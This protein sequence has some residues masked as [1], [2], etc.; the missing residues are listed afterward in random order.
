MIKLK[1]TDVIRLTS[2]LI[3]AL[4]LFVIVFVVDF[5][6]IFDR[7]RGLDYTPSS[8]ITNLSQDLRLSSRAKTILNATHPT[9][10]PSESFNKYCGV[11]NSD[12]VTLG[13]YS[14][15]LIYLYD[16]NDV[17]L[18]GIKQST[19]AHELLHAVWDRTPENERENLEKALSQIYDNN[20]KKLESR[21]KLYSEK[22]HYDEL[23]SI[24]GTEIVMYAAAV[25][26][27]SSC[28]DA[29]KTLSDHYAKYF[30][31]QSAVVAF[32]KQYES[33]FKELEAEANALYEQIQ[34]N[35]AQIASL[36]KAC[37]DGITSLN[38]AIAVFNQ[39]ANNGYFQNLNVFEAE[40][41]RLVARQTEL[42]NNYK[43]L[44]RLVASTN[45][46]IDDFNGNIAKTQKLIDNINSST[47]QNIQKIED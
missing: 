26:P 6:V 12:T 16:T 39:R 29:V 5:S 25:C 36:T 35:Q 42:Q 27:E 17:G 1:K 30:N 15:G 43:E 20:T 24:I 37:E 4:S 32:F 9:I 31:D 46:L 10:L 34:K 3:I 8:E 38:A 18:T 2:L 28:D 44:E 45:K 47:D 19:L 23:H 11:T 33:K 21:L 13:C 7:I 40:R 14:N 22:D 41:S